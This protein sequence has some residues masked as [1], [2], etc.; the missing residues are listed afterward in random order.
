VEKIAVYRQH[1][2]IDRDATAFELL[3]R[4]AVDC[5][6]LTSPAIAR[7]FLSAIDGPIS[8]RIRGNEIR[9]VTNGPRISAVVREHGLNVAV[10]SPEPTVD[11]LIEALIEMWQ[12]ERQ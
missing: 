10:E 7:V 11:S 3:R 5:V 8:E 6:T 1:E 9:L 2:S 4:G 12:A